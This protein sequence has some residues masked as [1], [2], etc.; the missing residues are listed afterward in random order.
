MKAES[1]ERNRSA[2]SSGSV[3][4]PGTFDSVG[5]HAQQ[6][7]IREPTTTSSSSNAISMG[8][9]FL[10]FFFPDSLRVQANPTP[11]EDRRHLKSFDN[12]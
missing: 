11:P 3:I 6:C 1:K 8:F 5:T 10:F 4:H 7:H 9:L 12:N 2:S